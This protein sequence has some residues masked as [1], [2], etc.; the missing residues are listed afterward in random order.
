MASDTGTPD[1]RTIAA[2]HLKAITT[3]A[4]ETEDKH[5]QAELTLHG[6]IIA[7]LLD[8]AGAIREQTAATDH[9]GIR[10][11]LAEIAHAA[12]VRRAD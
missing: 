6:G 8:V 3:L 10:D 7:A 1:Y 11:D 4:A 12:R 5:I 2:S 9:G